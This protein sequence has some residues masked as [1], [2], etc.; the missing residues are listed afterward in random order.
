MATHRSPSKDK[1]PCCSTEGPGI[2]TWI[3]SAVGEQVQLWRRH[4]QHLL[5]LGRYDGGQIAR[6]GGWLGDISFSF[7]PLGK[8]Q[9][10]PLPL[11]H[12]QNFWIIRLHKDSVGWDEINEAVSFGEINTAAFPGSGWVCSLWVFASLA[13]NKKATGPSQHFYFISRLSQVWFLWL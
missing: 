12:N 11:K 9:L 1:A 4:W 7:Q 6:M 3:R 10:F 2:L 5:Q 13:H 8:H